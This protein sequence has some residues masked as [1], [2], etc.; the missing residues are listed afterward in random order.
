MGPFRWSTSRKCKFVS[1]GSPNNPPLPGRSVAVKVRID[2]TG[3]T[4]LLRLGWVRS[5]G[6]SP[7]KLELETTKHK[8][9]DF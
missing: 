2:P 9:L 6:S 5:S 7:L 1:V 3:H 8:G 4:D